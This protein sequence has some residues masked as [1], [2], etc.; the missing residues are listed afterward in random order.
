MLTIVNSCGTLAVMDFRDSPADAEF[1]A[2]ARRVIEAAV[3]AL[4]GPEPTTTEDRLP[5]FRQFQR[6]IRDAGYAG[7]SWPQEYGGRDASLTEQAIFLQEY[8]RAGA[9]DRLNLLG[10]GLAGPTIIDFPQI[11]GAA[12]S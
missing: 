7:L 5:Y 6:A 2:E 10:E 12:A 1:R 9:P 11:V 4:P 3:A 8:D